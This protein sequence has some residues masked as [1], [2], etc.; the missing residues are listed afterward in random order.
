MTSEIPI[1][2]ER[3][4]QKSVV[5]RRINQSSGNTAKKREDGS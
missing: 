2:G 1:L 4:R 3:G 5:G